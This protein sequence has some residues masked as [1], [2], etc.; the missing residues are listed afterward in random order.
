LLNYD[1]LS[2]PTDSGGWLDPSV[3]AGF[4]EYWDRELFGIEIPPWRASVV[5]IISRLA[6][7]TPSRPVVVADMGC[8]A[9]TYARHLLAAGVPFEYHGYDH[10]ERVLQAACARWQFLPNQNIHFH[11]MDARRPSWPIGDQTCDVVIWDT[12]LRFCPQPNTALAESL[13]ISRAGVI[14]ARTPLYDQMNREEHRYYD[15]AAPSTD[16]K[17]DE[18]FFTDEA[19]SAGFTLSRGIGCEDTHLISR[20]P[21]EHLGAIGTIHRRERAMHEAYVRL[22]IGVLFKEHVG[23]W[24]IFGAGE[25]TRWLVQSFGETLRRRVKCILDDAAEPGQRLGGISVRKPT[26]LMTHEVDAVLVS[27]DTLEEPLY[28]RAKEWSR[29]IVPVARLYEGLP[30]GPYDKSPVGLAH[31]RS[32]PSSHE[33]GSRGMLVAGVAHFK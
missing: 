3:V 12:T 1:R 13:R 11:L 2:E 33:T 10:N 8:G 14:L 22:R 29:N 21:I 4:N 30:T 19:V 18:Q 27:S 31:T 7:L 16:W 15:M 20:T 26:E 28:D 9:A 6:S 24:A 32:L 23:H 17:F 5:Q 25:H